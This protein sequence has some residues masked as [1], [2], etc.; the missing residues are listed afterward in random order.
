[1]TDALLFDWKKEDY[2]AISGMVD[3]HA[4]FSPLFN[5]NLEKLFLDLKNVNRINSSGV[6]RWVIALE[7]LRD[8][9]L[10]YINCSFSVV[11]QLSM[12]PEFLTKKSH[13]ESFD[14]RYVCEN[15]NTS[16]VVTLVV[17]YDI[18]AGLSKYLDGPD[19]LCPNCKSKMEFDHNP[20]SYLFFL[21]NLHNKKK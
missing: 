11:E 5:K 3:E 17:G 19:R 21:S 8:V 7:K 12:V 13:V 16:Q 14:A 6:R 1:M 4:D 18:E 9:E 10:H 15:C 2:V 20:D